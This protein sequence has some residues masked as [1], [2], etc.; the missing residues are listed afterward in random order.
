MSPGHQR[1]D[2]AALTHLVVHTE[3]VLR[4]LGIVSAI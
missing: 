2:P 1:G 4:P 3:D